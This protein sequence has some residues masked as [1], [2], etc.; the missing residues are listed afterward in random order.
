M[1][2]L[3]KHAELELGAAG[4]AG[5]DGYNGLLYEAI[6]A[7]VRLFADQGHSGFS[8]PMVVG[9]LQKLLMFEPLTPLTGDDTEWN[10]VSD[11]LWQNR[12]C[13]HVFKGEG[14]VAV[15]AAVDTDGALLVTEG[16]LLPND[17]GLPRNLV[18]LYASGMWVRLEVT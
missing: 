14:G 10:Q 12:R 3:V 15:Q 5:D 2:N 7:H 11:G 8:A 13:S 17:Q 6:M 4:I 18:A 9:A 1:S 16:E